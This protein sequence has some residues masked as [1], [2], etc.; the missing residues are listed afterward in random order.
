MNNTRVFSVRE[1]TFVGYIPHDPPEGEITLENKQGAELTVR[2]H[3]R[4]LFLSSV[5][6][7]RVFAVRETTFAN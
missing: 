6:N 2:Y 7:T 1:T 4:F 5:N 3:S